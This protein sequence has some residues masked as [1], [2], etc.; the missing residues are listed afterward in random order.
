MSSVQTAD[1]KWHATLSEGSSQMRAIGT[2]IENVADTNATVLIRGESGVGKDLV[3][4]AVH[5]SSSRRQGPFVKINC[6]LLHKI[7]DCELTLPLR[8]PR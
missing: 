7:V 1:P 6:T 8:R 2:L 5:A 3:A 4:R